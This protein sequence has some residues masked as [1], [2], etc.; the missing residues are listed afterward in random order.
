MP[1]KEDWLRLSLLEHYAYCPR[2]AALLMDGVWEDN[3][4]TVQGQAGHQR[5]DSGSTDYRRGVK[6]H[7]SVSVASSRSQIFGVVDSVEEG[8]EGQICPVE[9]K[10]GR[11]VGDLFPS[12]VQVVAQALC[13]EEMLGRCV[14][15]AA[16]FLISEKRRI[17][18]V[19]D[20]V[21]CDVIHAIEEARRVLL[22]G[23]PVEPKAPAFKCRSC[24]LAEV[25]QPAHDRE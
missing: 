4:L 13:L 17:S 6:V 16:I 19:V 2:Q 3:H 9:H 11:G 23:Q 10:R 15:E 21:R 14:P 1:E 5:V 7:H 8:V 20:K 12:T 25:C 22:S 18:I 24:S